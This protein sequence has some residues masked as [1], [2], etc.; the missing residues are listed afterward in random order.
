MAF[1]SM[2]RRFSGPDPTLAIA[3]RSAANERT[4]MPTVVR[5]RKTNIVVLQQNEQIA[6]LCRR[7]DIAILADDAGWWLKFVGDNGEVDCYG[8]PYASYNE[9]LWAAKA[10]AEFGV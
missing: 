9:A 1:P 4:A 3:R 6:E 7:G 2:S 8:I 10:A 5:H